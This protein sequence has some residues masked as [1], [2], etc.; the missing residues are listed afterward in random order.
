MKT[1]FIY[2]DQGQYANYRD[3]IESA[4]GQI[5]LSRN[6]CRTS[7][8]DALLLPGGG[9]ILG[10]L[11][12]SERYLLQLFITTSRPVLGI[13]RGM[14]A[15]NV[16]FDGTLHRRIPGHQS[17]EGDLIHPTCATGLLGSLL[18]CAI[19]VNSCHHQAVDH[20]GHNLVVLQ[21]SEDNVVEGLCHATR[22]IIGVQWHPERQSYALRREDAVDAAPLFEYFLSL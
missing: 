13:C 22:P 5:L 20:L 9:D 21:R 10:P 17:P 12:E 19:T 7:D 15:L 16:Y 4:G 8:C 18:G 6:L 3:A 11:D 14:Q 2:G 1:V